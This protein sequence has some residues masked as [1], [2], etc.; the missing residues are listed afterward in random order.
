LKGNYESL[1]GE[2]DNIFSLLRA[3]CPLVARFPG[4]SV[5]DY[6]LKRQVNGLI[7]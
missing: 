6:V 4:V 2:T 5:G 7:T 3:K 1:E